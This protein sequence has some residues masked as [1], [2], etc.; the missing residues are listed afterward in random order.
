MN[1]RHANV[2]ILAAAL[3]SAA[4][5]LPM[6][7]AAAVANRSE[8]LGPNIAV[9]GGFERGSDPGSYLDIPA[10][11]RYLEGWTSVGSHVQLIGTYWRAKEGTRSLAL[12]TYGN[13]PTGSKITPPGTSGVRQTLTTVTGRRYRVTFY[14]AGSPSD[15]TLSTV[16]LAIGGTSKEYTFRPDT[17]AGYRAMRWVRRSIVYTATAASTP[18]ALYVLDTHDW[19]GLDNVQ[20]RAIC[21][22]TGAASPQP[23]ATGAPAMVGARR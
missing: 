22:A 20:V 10:G 3:L 7:T 12:N 1:V 4:A 5:L 15:H 23:A 16:Q 11:T 19:I 21:D 6:A 14:Q 13:Y 17:K 8:T 2:R 18:L 9:N